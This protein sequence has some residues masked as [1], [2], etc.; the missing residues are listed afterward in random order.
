MT[1]ASSAAA[2]DELS[3]SAQRVLVCVGKDAGIDIVEEFQVP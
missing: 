3:A 1:L 2:A